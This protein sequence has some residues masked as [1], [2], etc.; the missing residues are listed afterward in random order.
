MSSTVTRAPALRSMNS[1]ARRIQ[2]FSVGGGEGG[3]GLRRARGERGPLDHDSQRLLPSAL[4][5]VAR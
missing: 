2:G 4:L 5:T 1:I 3:L